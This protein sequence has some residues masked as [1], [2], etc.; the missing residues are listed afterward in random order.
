MYCP[1]CSQQQA[2]DE[3][4]FCPR[5]G[6]QLDAVQRLLAGDGC[7]AAATG[8]ELR[9]AAA[10]ARKR[11]VL[12]GATRMLVGAISV[13]LRMVSTVA[14]TPLQAVIIPLLLVWAAI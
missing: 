14:G 11:E 7:V 2:S 5:C 13:A 6:L 4:R 1:E 9:A 12:W 10:P 3:V 8:E